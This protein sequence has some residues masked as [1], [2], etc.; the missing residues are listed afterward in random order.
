MKGL[1]GDL[2]DSGVPGDAVRDTKLLGQ[3]S[4]ISINVRVSANI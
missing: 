2:G 3:L 1:K 4:S